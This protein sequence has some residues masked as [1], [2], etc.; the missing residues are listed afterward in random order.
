MAWVRCCGGAAKST[1]SI[2]KDGILYK[3]FNC[4]PYIPYNFYPG[5]KIAGTLTNNSSVLTFNV[6]GGSYRQSSA[7]SEVIDI[8]NINALSVNISSVST[9]VSIGLIASDQLHDN[10]TYTR[11]KECT[12]TG[13]H[14]LDTSALSGEYR[15]V[16]Y[17]ATGGG[18]SSG[19]SF[20][21]ITLS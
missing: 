4:Y 5:T 18:T 9:T 12:T 8:T 19:G 21:E 11:W 15:M 13:V 16:I 14:Y 7:I 10:Y 20:S 3:A 2:Y 1:K 6:S 17:T